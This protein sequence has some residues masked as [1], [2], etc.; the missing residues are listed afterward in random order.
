MAPL[1]LSATTPAAAFTVARSGHPARRA[2]PIRAQQQQEQRAADVSRRDVGI[3]AT[4]A[5]AAGLAASA[6]P[7]H[8]F[9]GLGGPSAA[10]RYANETKEMIDKTNALLALPRT[11]PAKKDAVAEVRELTNVW[12]AK[13]RRDDRFAGKPSYGNMYSVLN[14]ISGHYNSFGPEAPIPKKRLDRITKEL[15]DAEKL[16]ARNR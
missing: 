1:T 9:L 7:A 2:A 15:A 6:P 4:L 3:G 8:A 16:L 11:D 13:Y 10:E 12:V 5:A 14:A